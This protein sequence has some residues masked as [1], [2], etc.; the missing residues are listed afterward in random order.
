MASWI[1]RY[2]DGELYPVWQEMRAGVPG[3]LREDAEEVVRE[4]MTR[5]ALNCDVIVERL[6]EA[7]FVFAMPDD[8][9]V[10]P[11]A[12]DTRAIAQLERSFGE[13]PLALRGCFEHVGSVDLLGDGGAALPHVSYHQDPHEESGLLPDPL[14]L[15]SAADFLS[16]A[17]SFRDGGTVPF[18]PDD[19][20]KANISGSSH[21]L[22]LPG[23]PVDPVLDGVPRRPGITL[24]EYLRLSLAWGGFPGY[25]AL[26]L[27]RPL[28]PMLEVLRR[29]L[30][31]F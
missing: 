5:V 2:R 29:D 30:R 16:L 22:E 3:A 24:V 20:H 11:T 8:T 6:N 7:G 27:D 9:R 31:M 1:S 23:S 18:A 12:A 13:L 21:S 25:D 4:T 17:E 10:R 15:P 14:C 28:P 26:P 19:L